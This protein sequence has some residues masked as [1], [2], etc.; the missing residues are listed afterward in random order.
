VLDAS[1]IEDFEQ[2]TPEGW[3]GLTRVAGAGGVG[4]AAGGWLDTV[5]VRSVRK[6]VGA[7]DWSGF[8]HLELLAHSAA[9]SGALITVALESQNPATKANDLLYLRFRVDWEGWQRLRLPLRAFAPSHEPIGLHQVNGIVFASDWGPSTPTPDTKLLFDQIQVVKLPPTRSRVIGDMDNDLLLWPALM[10]EREVVMEGEVA[11]RWQDLAR[12]PSLIWRGE[13]TDWRPFGGLHLWVHAATANG[14][15]LRVVLWSDSL[16]TRERDAYT[17][18]RWIDHEGW[19]EWLLSDADFQAAYQPQGWGQIDEVEVVGG[20][21]EG[22]DPLPDTDL[23]IDDVRVETRDTSR[24]EAFLDGEDPS[25]FPTSAEVQRTE[26]APHGGGA[27]LRWSP[28]APNALISLRRVPHD[29][30]GY[31]ALAFWARLTGAESAR[32]KVLVDSDHKAVEGLDC[33][34][35]DCE[36]PGGAWTQVRCPLKDFQAFGDPLGWPN[37]QALHLQLLDSGGG[38]LPPGMTIDLDDA[39]LLALR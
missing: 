31:E 34:R 26:E 6:A 14:Q 30:Q 20:G 13:L 9:P 12:R 7:L 10:P 22:I 38:P 15:Q 11:G 23:V 36:I 21:W 16:Q 29:W 37:V 8:T 28:L 4:Q 35:F 18:D 5:R 3:Q 32:L 1:L 17:C 27:A 25:R 33:Y 39:A 19:A 2:P 24:D